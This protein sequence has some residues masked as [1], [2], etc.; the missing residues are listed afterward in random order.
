MFGGLGGPWG[1]QPPP[2]LIPPPPP[3]HHIATPLFNQPPPWPQLASPPPPPMAPQHPPLTLPLLPAAAPMPHPTPAPL[4]PP[5]PVTVLPPP[6]RPVQSTDVLQAALD[7]VAQA[8]GHIANLRHQLAPLQ[9]TSRFTIQGGKSI[10]CIF[11]G[12]LRGVKRK[13]L[14]TALTSS[15]SGS[16]HLDWTSGWDTEMPPDL[17]A[18]CRPLHCQLCDVQVYPLSFY[19]LQETFRRLPLCKPRC[20][21][22]ER[23]M[24][25]TSGATSPP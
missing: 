1:G 2:P 16:H 15:K 25:S 21:T 23:L 17:L 7:T 19:C 24:T 12:S 6:I 18:K 4:S 8:Q 11:E 20:T 5:S 3:Q 13:S 10:D 9:P 22:R 14:A